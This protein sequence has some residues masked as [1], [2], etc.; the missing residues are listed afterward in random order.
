MRV[1]IIG[2]GAISR[3]HAEAY[4]NIGFEMVACSSIDEARGREFAEEFGC[5]LLDQWQ[6]VCR[7]PKVDF[8]DVCTFPDFRLE[9]LE[10][11]AAEKKHVQVQK[12]IATN[13]GAARRM[14]ELAHAAGIVLGVISQ[15]RFEDATQFLKRAIAQGR[16]GRILEADAYLKWYRSPE[17]YARPVKGSWDA[18]GGGALMTQGIHSVDLLLWFAGPMRLVTGEWKIG[19]LH[20]IESEDMVSAVVRYTSGATGVIQASTAFWP[21]YPERI[22]IH[23]TKGSAILTG[24]RLTAWDVRDD[25]GEPAPVSAA[26]RSPVSGAFDPADIPLEPFE[27]QFRDFAAAIEEHREPLVSGEEGYRALQVVEAVYRSCREGHGIRMD[28]ANE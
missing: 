18:E 21:G 11:C 20:A 25:S 17:Y 4:R 1:G 15:H 10:L 22:E 7:H 13:L 28:A 3:K 9:P 12:P 19:A 16:L 14:V 8:V 6:D 5:E 24:D 27:R 26:T 23:G 2:T